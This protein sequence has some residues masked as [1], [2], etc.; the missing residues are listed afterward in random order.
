MQARTQTNPLGPGTRNFPV[1]WPA[2]E[3][4]ELGRMAH[5][6]GQSL[7]GLIK[8]L[9]RI[10][11]QAETQRAARAAALLV[12]FLGITA[13]QWLGH[14][15]VDVRRARASVRVRRNEA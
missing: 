2:E 15:E 5:E 10:G 14:D 7:G 13:A 12:I 8:E 3:L 9:V 4:Q 11:R 1:N 6:R